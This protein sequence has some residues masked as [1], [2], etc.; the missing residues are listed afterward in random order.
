MHFA[1]FSLRRCPQEVDR[2]ETKDTIRLSSVRM[3]K[4][5]E[6]DEQKAN[7]MRYILW[8]WRHEADMH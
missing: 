5:Q 4:R 2:P 7:D 3:R 8:L 6:N 1:I